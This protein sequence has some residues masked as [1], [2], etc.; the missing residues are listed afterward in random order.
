MWP[1]GAPKIASAGWPTVESGATEHLG[2]DDKGKARKQLLVGGR[3][4]LF[5]AAGQAAWHPCRSSQAADS[6]ASTKLN[7]WRRGEGMFDLGRG[8]PAGRRPPLPSRQLSFQLQLPQRLA[9]VRGGWNQ[10]L[11]TSTHSSTVASRWIRPI[12]NTQALFPPA[13]KGYLRGRQAAPTGSVFGR[14]RRKG[15]SGPC[16]SASSTA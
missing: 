11:G 13:P 10:E 4:G 12:Q 6:H 14:T 7:V 5:R 3:G 9:A 15:T 1:P 2:Q 16:S 8:G